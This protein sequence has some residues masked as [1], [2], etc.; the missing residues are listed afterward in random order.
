MEARDLLEGTVELVQL[1][2]LA[3]REPQVNKDRKDQREI[4]EVLALLADREPRVRLEEMARRA[5]KDRRVVL[6]R[7]VPQAEMATVEVPALQA[8]REEQVQQGKLDSKAT[9][10]S[11]APRASLVKLVR[12]DRKE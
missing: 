6:E 2:S 9:K 8:R 4:W 10:D 3:A 7:K 12:K 11:R 5:R 1:G